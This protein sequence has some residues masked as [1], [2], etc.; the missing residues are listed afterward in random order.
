MNFCVFSLS[1]NTSYD[2]FR[3]VP[4]SL[5]LFW[6]HGQQIMLDLKPDHDIVCNQSA[7]HQICLD[8]QY[9]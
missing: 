4:N 2:A 5:A 1:S 8:G 6:L 7:A 3:C 9:Y